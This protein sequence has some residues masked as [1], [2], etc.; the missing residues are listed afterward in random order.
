MLYIDDI[1]AVKLNRIMVLRL[2]EISLTSLQKNIQDISPY[3]IYRH[4]DI[5]RKNLTEASTTSW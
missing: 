4:S 3:E 5:G 1:G 2:Q